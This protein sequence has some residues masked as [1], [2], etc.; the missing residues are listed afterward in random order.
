[1]TN[2]VKPTTAQVREAAAAGRA[3]AESG[4]GQWNPY[5]GGDTALLARVWNDAHRVAGGGGTRATQASDGL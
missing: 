4:D 2:M 3:Y 1:M 5:A